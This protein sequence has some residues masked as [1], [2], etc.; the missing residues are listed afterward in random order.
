LIAV[1]M[2]VSAAGALSLLPVTLIAASK[3]APRTR[4]ERV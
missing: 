3:R 2:V 4:G 1:T